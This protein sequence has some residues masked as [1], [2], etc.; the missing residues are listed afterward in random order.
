MF[1]GMFPLMKLIKIPKQALPNICLYNCAAS[2]VIYASVEEKSN[3]HIYLSFCLRSQYNV[4]KETLDS[5]GGQRP[6]AAQT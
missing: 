5:L 3:P 1:I 2:P 4:G 6:Q